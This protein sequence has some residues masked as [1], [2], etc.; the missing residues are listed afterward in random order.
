[1][2]L[3]KRA[4]DS[5]ALSLLTAQLSECNDKIAV[6]FCIGGGGDMVLSDSVADNQALSLM[7]A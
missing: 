6:G 2:V 5:Q 7:T 3:S 4:T 1:M